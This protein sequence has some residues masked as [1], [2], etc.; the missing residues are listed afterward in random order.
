[1]RAFLDSAEHTI[2]PLAQICLRLT[3][4]EAPSTLQFAHKLLGDAPPPDRPDPATAPIAPSAAEPYAPD[5]ALAHLNP[6]SITE[7]GLLWFE[8]KDYDRARAAWEKS[9]LTGNAGGL[10]GLG[11]LYEDGL[12]VP[13]DIARALEYYELAAAKNYSRARDA[14][15]RIRGQRGAT[16]DRAQTITSITQSDI[17]KWERQAIQGFKESQTEST[18]RRT[19]LKLGCTPEY[20]DRVVEYAR[21][22]VRKQRRIGGIRLVVTGVLLIYMTQTMVIGKSTLLIGLLGLGGV[23]TTVFGMY[24]I[25]TGER[26]RI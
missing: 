13:K 10:N 5:P 7:E 17:E 1:M 25:L 3:N 22:E 14:V 12:G 11:M 6:M 19:L 20:S 9:A 15:A 26:E 2:Y 23:L 21:I 16:A 8:Q 24:K 4:P 18:I